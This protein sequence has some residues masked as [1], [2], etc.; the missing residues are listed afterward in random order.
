MTGTILGVDLHIQSKSAATLLSTNLLMCF[1]WRHPFVKPALSIRINRIHEDT[2]LTL[3][4]PVI[5]R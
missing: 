1:E 4:N 3:T 2:F 5:K